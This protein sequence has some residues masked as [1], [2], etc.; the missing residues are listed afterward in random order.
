MFALERLATAK[1]WR[2]GDGE[3]GLEAPMRRTGVVARSVGEKP[4]KCLRS[5][6]RAIAR[7]PEDEG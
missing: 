1:V 3:L 5:D 7:L 4:A 2:A 6:H